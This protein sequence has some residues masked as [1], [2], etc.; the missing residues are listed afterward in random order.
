MRKVT[1][2]ETRD[3]F[4]DYGGLPISIN[5][6]PEKLSGHFENSNKKK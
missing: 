2:P 5:I 1:R 6:D 3:V 4:S